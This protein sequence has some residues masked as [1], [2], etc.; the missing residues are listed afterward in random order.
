MRMILTGV[1]PSGHP[2]AARSLTPVYTDLHDLAWTG[3]LARLADALGKK[4]RLG[5]DLGPGAV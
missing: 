4:V 2:P 1:A 3:Q 5:G